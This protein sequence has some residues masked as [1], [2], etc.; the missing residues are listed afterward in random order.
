MA[1]LDQPHGQFCAVLGGIMAVRMSY[2][3]VK[4]TVVNG[5]VRDL[6]EL[7]ESKLPVC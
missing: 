1:I 4:G 7:R 6:G 3:G 5:R 2:L